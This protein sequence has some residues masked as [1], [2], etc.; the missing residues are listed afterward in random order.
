[1]LRIVIIGLVALFFSS[2]SHKE[3][4][5]QLTKY[6][7]DGTARP[8][9]TIAPILDTTSFEASWSLSDEISSLIENRLLNKGTLFLNS[10]SD[11]YL[12]SSE[13]PF[14]NDLSWVKKEFYPNEFVVF[15]EIVQHELEPVE[16]TKFFDPSEISSNLNIAV[17]IRIIDIRGTT[18]KIVLQELLHESQ[19]VSRT[20]IP[21][22]YD[23]NPWGSEDYNASPMSIAHVSLV[24]QLVERI[25]DYVLLAKSRW[26]G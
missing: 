12:N 14:G 21:F 13:N 7:D 23:Q 15:L 5:E 4:Q 9:I 2:C 22:D 10:E 17:R 6:Y 1:M 19:Y 20:L 3:E 25:N 11:K 26:N 18:P 24:K 16:K 8:V